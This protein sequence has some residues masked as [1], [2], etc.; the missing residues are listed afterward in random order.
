MVLTDSAGSARWWLRPRWWILAGL[1]AL[2]GDIGL[3]AWGWAR[4]ERWAE[5]A[6]R[7]C[8]QPGFP[9]LPDNSPI[10]WTV[11]VSIG[12]AVLAVLVGA[13]LYARAA[14]CSATARVGAVLVVVPAVALALGLLLPGLMLIKPR[15]LSR[16]VDGSGIPCPFG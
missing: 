11:L 8:N 2:V 10:G 12:L 1:A 15:T 3:M 6:S 7:H 5:D 14:D 16:G 4:D 13:V 9:Q